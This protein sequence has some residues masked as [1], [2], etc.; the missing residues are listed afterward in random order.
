LAVALTPEL[1]IGLVVVVLVTALFFVVLK[2]LIY[3]MSAVGRG[4]G[5]L[6]GASPAREGLSPRARQV[7]A[8]A[9]RSE[10]TPVC[11]DN[12]CRKINP[13]GARFCARCGRK[14]TPTS[15][16]AGGPR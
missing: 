2:S 3:A 12:K 4:L 16:E 11:P 6:V 15:A 9:S 8:A 7:P 13:P 5:R 10:A 1:M 14:L